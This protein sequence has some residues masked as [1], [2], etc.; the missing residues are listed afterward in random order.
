MTY[1]SECLAQLY[2]RVLRV[3]FFPQEKEKERKKR[4]EAEKSKRKP[5][6]DM[7][8]GSY[9]VYVRKNLYGETGAHP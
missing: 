3:F 7:S 1:K 9:S 4:M 6:V 8:A 5:V 2:T